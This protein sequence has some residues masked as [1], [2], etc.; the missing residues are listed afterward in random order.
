MALFGKSS[1]LGI[2]IADHT[3]EVAEVEKTGNKTKITNIGRIRLK[4]G[5][6]QN[7]RIQDHKALEV[8]VKE[9]LASA[10]P[11]PIEIKNVNMGLPDSIVY[12]TLKTLPPHAKSEREKLFR[13]ESL[14]TFPLTQ[15]ELY[16][17]VLPLKD[18]F[19]MKQVRLVLLQ[20]NKFWSQSFC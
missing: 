8:A 10:K 1:S 18:W 17:S 5:V 20:M 7:G 9:V 3:I 2:D 6:I 13:E 12:T 19:M 15:D 16:Y 14:A 4:D 11:E